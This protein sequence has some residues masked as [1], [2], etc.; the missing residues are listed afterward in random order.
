MPKLD[1][2]G[3]LKHWEARYLVEQTEEWEKWSLEVPYIQFPSEWSIRIIPP[4]T[5]AI[6][7]FRV[8]TPKA[9]FVSV[10][11][12]CYDR[13]GHFGEPYW[14]VYPHQGDVFR[15]AMNDVDALLKAISEAG[16]GV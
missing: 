16:D 12:D 15:C 7:R 5:N 14:E 1:V 13:L 10:Y 4:M 8:K 6:V 9:E 2:P 11:L 3:V